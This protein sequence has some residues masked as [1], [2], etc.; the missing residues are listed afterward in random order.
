VLVHLDQPQAPVGILVEE[1]LDQRGLAGTARAPQQ[2]VV[3]GMPGQEL[4]DIQIERRF[5]AVDPAQIGQPQPVRMPNGLQITA[6]VPPTPAER[7]VAFPVRRERRFRQQRLQPL[8]QDDAAF[9]Q[10]RID[11]QGN[12]RHELNRP[13]PGAA[14]RRD[15]STRSGRR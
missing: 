11:R 6:L 14:S 13:P 1:R 9:G 7:P 12:R 10:P 5:L 2:D 8:E 3:A 4:P 15:H